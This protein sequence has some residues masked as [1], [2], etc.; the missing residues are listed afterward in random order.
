MRDFT[1]F[2]IFEISITPGK[3][4]V[5]TI[6]APRHFFGFDLKTSSENVKL[7]RC[8]LVWQATETVGGVTNLSC[9]CSALHRLHTKCLIIVNFS[10]YA[11]RIVYAIA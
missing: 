2:A 1:F 3:K 8:G 6:V 9:P 7:I 5:I 11:T 10:N 4:V